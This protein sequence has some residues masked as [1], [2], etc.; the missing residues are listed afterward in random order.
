MSDD[1]NAKIDQIAETLGQ[2]KVPDNIKGLISLLAGSLGQSNQA[3][4]ASKENEEQ[5]KPE[6]KSTGTGNVAGNDT[7]ENIEMVRRIKKVMDKMSMHSDPRVNLLTAVKPFLNSKR[8]KRLNNC[9]KILTMTNMA[10]L[11]DEFDKGI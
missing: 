2:D 6:E 1:L 4:T 7:D 10:R 3:D 9:I 8:Q 11:V 5:P